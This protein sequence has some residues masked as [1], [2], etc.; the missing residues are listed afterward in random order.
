MNVPI[1]QIAFGIVLIILLLG[2]AAFFGW[3]QVQTLRR[4]RQT[5]DLPPED[6]LYTRNQAQRRLVSSVLM[7]V[8][9]GLLA[10][11][12]AFEDRINQLFDQAAHNRQLGEAVPA[13]PEQQRFIDF[14]GTFWVVTLLVLLSMIGLA[15]VDYF[16]IRRYARR[17][18]RQIQQDRRAMIENEIAR[19]RSQR[20]GHD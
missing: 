3:R 8:L 7:V 10:V 2:M 13:D 11:H 20:N 16:A 19:L 17:H 18:Y 6:R 4:L 12:F 9:A 14:Y 1:G 15:A 5:P